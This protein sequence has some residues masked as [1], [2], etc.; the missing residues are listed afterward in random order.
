MSRKKW[1]GTGIFLLILFG[2]TSAWADVP[3]QISFQGKLTDGDGPL[4][5]TLKM[6]FVLYDA[7]TGGTH[8]WSEDQMVEVKDGIYNVALGSVNPIDAKPLDPDGVFLEVRICPPK[9]PELCSPKVM[10]NLKPRQQITA[11]AYAIQADQAAWSASSADS[12][13]LNG[14]PASH[15]LMNASEAVSTANLAPSA[16]TAVKMADGAALEEIKD[17]DG[18]NSGLDA[19]LLDGLD[20]KS[21]ID[22]AKDEVRTPISSLPFS[23]TQAGSYYLTGDLTHGDGIGITVMADNVTI[24]LM[25]FCIY[26][27]GG[28][29]GFGIVGHNDNLTVRNGTIKGFASGGISVSHGSNMVFERLRILENGTSGGLS[30]M[31]S[32]KG[33]IRNCLIHKNGNASTPDHLGGIRADGE[34][35]I[36]DNVV[37]DNYYHGIYAVD[38]VIRNNV[39]RDNWGSGIRTSGSLVE[40]NTVLS[41]NGRSDQANS[42]LDAGIQSIYSSV[43]KN[44]LVA[45]NGNANIRIKQGASTGGG[46]NVIEN[47][48]IHTS[49]VGIYFQSQGNVYINNR[50]SEHTGTNVLG[51]TGNTNGGGNIAY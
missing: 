36:Q 39:V 40:N 14:R 2:V 26:Q 19:D 41:N 28:S 8:L 16:V 32:E 49:Y 1:I 47:N 11:S 46:R 10:E 35:V 3:G 17:N 50:M 29:T 25:G 33:I 21:I 7:E 30:L 22:A 20:S 4:T 6:T 9:D 31:W 12:A 45:Y 24:D 43:I 5:G 48:N 51:I 18:E 13:R 15:Y 34:Y 44:N 37:V 23:I 38:S 27:A 42:G